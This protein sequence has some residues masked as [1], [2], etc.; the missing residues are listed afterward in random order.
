MRI[1]Q[2]STHFLD[3]EGLIVKKYESNITTHRHSHDFIEIVFVLS[4]SGAHEI[5]NTAYAIAPGCFYIVK[6]GETHDM[7]FSE[8][9]AY[10][11][12]FLK[13]EY[14]AG[15][16]LDP[17]DGGSLLS[18]ICSLSQSES[19]VCFDADKRLTMELHIPQPV[20]GIRQAQTWQ[21]CACKKLSADPVS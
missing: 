3:T 9:S 11:N 12:I 8:F 5:G 6:S 14:L 21:R 18:F 20:S 19:V 1:Y 7:R 4:G 2:K 17:D 16:P 15:I 10:Y 13:D